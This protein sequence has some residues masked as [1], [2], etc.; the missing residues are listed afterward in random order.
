MIFALGYENIPYC[1]NDIRK[2]WKNTKNSNDNGIIYSN[3]FNN[4]CYKGLNHKDQG[5]CNT[6]SVRLYWI[7]PK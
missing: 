4:F 3:T 5:G 1:K 6:S 2:W 7:Y